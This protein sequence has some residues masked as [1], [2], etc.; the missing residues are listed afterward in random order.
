M[1]GREVVDGEDAEVQSRPD[2]EVV[3]ARLHVV[4]QHLVVAIGCRAATGE[5]V[6]AVDFPT[7][8]TVGGDERDLVDDRVDVGF[9]LRVD[10]RGE[11]TVDCRARRYA[12]QLVDRR[13]RRNELAAEITEVRVDQEVGEPLIAHN[14]RERRVS[15]ARARD[16]GEDNAACETHEQRDADRPQPAGAQVGTEAHPYGTHRSEPITRSAG[17]AR[18]ECA[19]RYVRESRRML[20]L[21]AG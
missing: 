17:A 3:V 20:R 18:A 1:L 4:D 5:E 12:R 9:A 19:T 16:R 21:R 8:R 7:E 2:R 13:P 11:H 14:P 10:R 15:P 6:R